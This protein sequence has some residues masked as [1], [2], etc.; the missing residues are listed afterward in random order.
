MFLCSRN[1]Y[2]ARGTVSK[3]LGGLLL[4]PPDHKQMLLG[5]EFDSKIG[6]NGIKPYFLWL[7]FFTHC[8]VFLFN[9]KDKRKQRKN[10]KYINLAR[11][12]IGENLP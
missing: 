6:K 10:N 1:P 2:I 3:Q 11:K 4:G 7:T 9:I 12:R 8:W 5:E